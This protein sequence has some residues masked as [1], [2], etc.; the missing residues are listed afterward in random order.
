MMVLVSFESAYID[1]YERE[2]AVVVFDRLRLLQGQM[3]MLFGVSNALR[4]AAL[5]RS[6]FQT[7][8]F[9][10]VCSNDHTELDPLQSSL[11]LELA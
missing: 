4:S 9:T 5:L 8:S 2:K 11:S 7:F 10:V 1:R 3:S 6:A